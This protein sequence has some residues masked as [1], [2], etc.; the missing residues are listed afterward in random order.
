M[1][2]TALLS[3]IDLSLLRPVF[4]L[5]WLSL[6]WEILIMLLSQ[7]PMTFCQTHCITCDYTCADWEGLCDHLRNVPWENSFKFDASGEFCWLAQVG[8]DVY[9]PHRKYKVKYHSSP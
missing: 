5:Q 9:I 4:I 2:L 1:I 6:H 7:F 3:C 8:I